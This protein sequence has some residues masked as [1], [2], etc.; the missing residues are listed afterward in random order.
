METL[1]VLARVNLDPAHDVNAERVTAV[2][3]AVTGTD[4]STAGVHDEL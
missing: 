4:S 1:I 2:S 3:P